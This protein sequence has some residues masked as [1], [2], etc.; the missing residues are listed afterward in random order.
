MRTAILSGWAQKIGS[1]CPK[2]DKII[3][4]VVAGNWQ[5]WFNRQDNF[6]HPN[7]RFDKYKTH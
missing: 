5:T 7:T 4:S 6:S 1:A 3:F 2:I